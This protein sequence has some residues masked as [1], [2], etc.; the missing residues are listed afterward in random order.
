[1]E[2]IFQSY[3]VN[4]EKKEKIAEVRESFYLFL[5]SIKEDIPEGREKSL[6]ITKLEEACMWAI[7][8]ISKEI[9]KEE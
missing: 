4:E 2:N 3:E 8:G 7:K 1:M 5:A 6:T 9:L